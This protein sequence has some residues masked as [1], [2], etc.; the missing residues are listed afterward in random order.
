MW[1]YNHYDELMHYG[2]LG[3]KWG[4]RR[5]D[6]QLARAKA[7][8]EKKKASEEVHDD[9]KRAHD[10]KS[11][12]SMSTKE[13][14]ERNNRLNMEKQYANLTKKQSIGKKA[15]TAFISTAGTIAGVA[16]AYGT[17]KNVAVPAVKKAIEKI[18]KKAI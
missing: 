1:Q 16:T 15:V 2:V 14:Q 10:S 3:M 13:L 12:K 6:A 17:Y 18:G 8:R 7:K 9:Y 4:V 5:S 11:V